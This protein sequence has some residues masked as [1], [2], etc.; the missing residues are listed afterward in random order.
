M[1]SLKGCGLNPQDTIIILQSISF[2]IASEHFEGAP[3]PAIGI[4]MNSLLAVAEIR[5]RERAQGNFSEGRGTYEAS[6]KM[7]NDYQSETD[8]E[9]ERW[10]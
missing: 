6:E 3:V 2:S 7:C 8:A 4:V 5:E 9:L 1:K 10:R